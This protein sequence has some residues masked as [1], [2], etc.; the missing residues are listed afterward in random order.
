MK[1]SAFADDNI[2]LESSMKNKLIFMTV[3]VILALIVG[4]ASTPAITTPDSFDGT[5]WTKTEDYELTF[6]GSNWEVRSGSTRIASGNNMSAWKV[7]GN[8]LIF[9]NDG[10]WNAWGYAAGEWALKSGIPGT[11]T[12]DGTTWTRTAILELFFKNGKMYSRDGNNQTND[13]NTYTITPRNINVRYSFGTANG[14]YVVDGN[15][16]TVTTSG[17]FG[18]SR[19]EGTPWTKL[20][21]EPNKF[22]GTTWAKTEN[23]ELIFIDDSNWEV[24]FDSARIASGDNMSAWKVDGN[25]LTFGN[26]GWWG[27]WGFAAGEWTL[28]SG[29]P[30]TDTLDGTTWTKTATLEIYFEN[31]KM[32]SK[33]GNNFTWTVGGNTYIVTPKDILFL[34]P[35]GTI[36]YK[37][38]TVDEDMLTFTRGSGPS[39]MEGSQWTKLEIAAANPYQFDGTTWTKTENYEL[40]ITDSNWEVRFDSKMI[41]SGENI[42]T[43]KLNGNTLTFGNKNWWGGWAL[44]A[45][46]WTLKSGTPER[47]SV[48]GTTWTRTAVHELNF[49]DG[50]I[51]SI[52]GNNKTSTGGSFGKNIGNSYFVSSRDI[53]VQFPDGT[54]GGAY[55][56]NGNILT[57]TTGRFGGIRLEGNP[58]TRKY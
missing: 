32:Y 5:A 25:I 4:C 12:L 19:L 42:R 28:K 14:T 18:A 53:F 58:W 23:F 10:W 43:W 22:D 41:A 8:T 46:E 31:G 55:A 38:Y 39:W 52:E 24:R 7:D 21:I 49:K 30:G 27:G 37:D 47:R 33:E 26:D 9:G 36:T 3:T 15:T 13:E 51:F 40:V 50:K 2:F 56:V 44:A 48:E 20:A 16:L 17:Q 54:N 35:D 11:D 29:T 57:V 1:L 6:R 34:Y 45:G